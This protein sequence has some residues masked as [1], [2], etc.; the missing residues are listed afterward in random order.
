MRGITTAKDLVRFLQN[1]EMFR[2]ANQQKYVN[3][4]T[5]RRIYHHVSKEEVERVTPL[6]L[7]TSRSVK[8]LVGNIM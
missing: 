3:A 6:D 4:I 2:G 5:T 8:T 7:V 1:Q